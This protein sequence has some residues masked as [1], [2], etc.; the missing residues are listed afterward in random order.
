[1]DCA[2]LVPEMLQEIVDLM[3][4]KELRI[5]TPLEE[6]DLLLTGCKQTESSTAVNDSELRTDS[7]DVSDELGS[8]V[9]S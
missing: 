7:M 2:R 3:T 9:N 5:R 6:L 1:V 4:E 8:T